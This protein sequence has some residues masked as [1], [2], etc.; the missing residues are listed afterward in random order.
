[1]KLVAFITGITGQDGSY[2]TELLLEKGYIVHGLIRRCSTHNNTVKICHLLTNRNLHLHYGDNT[3]S[4]SIQN[5]LTKISSNIFDRLEIYNLAAL[6]HVP[7]SFEAPEYTA[8]CDGIAPLYILEWI[9]LSE[10][11]D[12]IRFYQASTSELYGKVQEWPQNEKTPFYPRSPYGVAKQYA[13]WIVKN[14]RESYGI[15]AINGILF[16]HESPRRGEDFV[17]RKIT[18]GI[19]S[20]LLGKKESI[21][22]DNL[23]AKRDWGHAKDF[24]EGMWRMTQSNEPRDWVLAT[25]KEYSVRECITVAFQLRGI[26]IIWKGEGLQEV[27]IDKDTGIVRIRVNS[28]YF[29]PAEVERLLGDATD[30]KTLLGWAPKYAFKD[31]INEMLNHDLGI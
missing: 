29:R 27:G 28:S 3:D 7:Q 1:M 22:I 11:K 9:R 18:L 12:R 26:H 20:I 13:F 8:I 5:I 25:G 31:I 17:T 19:A 30:A 21:E 23:D 16:N 15:Y 10:H 6:S 4:M 14:Y 24:V 2:L